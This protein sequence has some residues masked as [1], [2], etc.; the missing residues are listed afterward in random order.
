MTRERRVQEAAEQFR[1][2]A[3]LCLPFAAEALSV[4]LVLATGKPGWLG[5]AV[6]S[7]FA[8]V[9]ILFVRLVLSSETNTDLYGAAEVVVRVDPVAAV[10]ERVGTAFSSSSGAM[11]GFPAA[12]PI[13]PADDRPK[14]DWMTV[15]VPTDRAFVRLVERELTEARRRAEVVAAEPETEPAREPSPPTSP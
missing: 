11:D 12:G 15:P 1:W 8:T 9:L 7:V 13:D 5:L 4:A 14:L 2:T 3:W 10:R 6:A